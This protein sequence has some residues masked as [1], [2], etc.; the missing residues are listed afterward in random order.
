[1]GEMLLVTRRRFGQPACK[2]QPN[3]V[4]LSDIS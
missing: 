3:R 2:G 4:W 1:M